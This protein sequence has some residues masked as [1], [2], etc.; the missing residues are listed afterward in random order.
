ME[1]IPMVTQ[2][3]ILS[4]QWDKDGDILAILQEGNGIV[5]L[6]S[7]STRKIVPL[8]TN[9]REPTFISWSKTGPQLAIGTAKGNLLIYNKT[10][11]Q[12]IPIVGKHGRRINCG[13]WSKGSNKLVLGSDDRTITVSNENGDTLLHFEVKNIPLQVLFTYQRSLDYSSAGQGNGDNTISSNLN[14]K[15]IVIYNILNDNEE[16][17]ELTFPTVGGVCK[18]GEIVSHEWIDEGLILVGFSIGYLVLFSS[19]K[20]DL[21]EEKFA[22]KFH[23]NNFITYSY[24]RQL[25]RVASAGDDG[26]RIFNISDFRESKEDYISPEDLEGGK[27]TTVEW[28]PDGQILSISTNAGNVYNF[29]AKMNV[30]STRYKTSIAYLSSLREVSIVDTLKRSRPIDVTLKLEPTVIA[31]G[32]KYVAAGMNNRV[33]FHRIATNNESSRGQGNGMIEQEY[34]TTVKEIQLNDTHCVVLLDS[35]AILHPIEPVAGA[36]SL[37]NSRTFP[38]REEGSFSKVNCVALCDNFLYYGTEAGTVEVFYLSEW[39]LLPGA[40]LRIDRSVKQIFPN[41]NGT[42]VVV[43]DSSGQSFLFNPVTGG[44]V[45]ASIIKFEDAPLGIVD[46]I[47]DFKDKN[48][49]ILNDGKSMHTYI[50]VCSSMKGGYLLKLG[51]MTVSGEGQIEVNPEKIDLPSGNS[52]LICIGGII[53]SQSVSGLVSYSV[54]PLFDHIVEQSNLPGKKNRSSSEKIDKKYLTKRF[55]QSLAALQLDIAWLAAVELDR[56]QY[57]LALGG[58]AMELLQ[59]E[60]ACRVY[61]QLGDAGMV[62]ALQE[63]LQIEDTML[64]AGQVAL[65]FS[66]YQRAQELFLVSS[67]PSA[68]LMM[69]RDLLQWDQALK[70]AQALNSKDI[71]DIYYN[72]GLQLELRGEADAALK[73]FEAALNAQDTQ[74]RN[75]CPESIAPLSMMGVARCNIQL[76]NIRPGIRLANELDDSQLY[77]DCGDLLEQQKQYSEAASLYQKAQQFEKVAQM[78]IKYLIK[79][80]KNR[81]NEATSIMEKVKNDQLNIAFAKLCVSAGRYSDACKAY[82]RASDMDKVSN[83]FIII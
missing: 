64:L 10:K 22:A 21:G 61:R 24:N 25:K 77:I 48:T 80:D 29:L 12:K 7:L 53:S 78:Y 59:I 42:R 60:L 23:S 72:Y 30:I 3:P 83:T 27:V 17:M 2:S 71:A 4:L 75:I 16:P 68:A 26:V 81:I 28:S 50:Y 31:L 73:N 20:R 40:E 44:G 79:A 33:Y 56:R 49:I 67:S 58:K 39:V 74:G 55:T 9:L 52:P 6:W 51:P 13:S 46:V 18:Y 43:I 66:D 57:W 82:E 63:C 5:P 41:S 19:G 8:E 35:K 34:M 54:H 36:N 47:W 15:S 62:M 65:L 76:G 32:G 38:S 70:L 37:N 14:G 11:K 1:E 69:R 45:N